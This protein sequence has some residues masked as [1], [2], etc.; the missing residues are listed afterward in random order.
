M[1]RGVQKVDSQGRPITDYSFVVWRGV[2]YCNVI[3]GAEYCR[4]VARRELRAGVPYIHC[5]PPL[6]RATTLRIIG[7]ASGEGDT[8]GIGWF[9][10]LSFPLSPML[11]IPLFTIF[12]LMYCVA[13]E[14]LDGA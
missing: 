12:A 4:A 13:T 7:A 14:L 2:V 8:I 5:P 9:Y 10:C 3:A 6:N 11:E 1:L